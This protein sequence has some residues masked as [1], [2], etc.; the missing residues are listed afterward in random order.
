ME[1]VIDM[2]IP[3]ILT[4]L[5]YVLLVIEAF[6]CLITWMVLREWYQAYVYRQMRYDGCPLCGTS[7]ESK[8]AYARTRGI[9]DPE[10]RD[11]VLLWCPHCQRITA[12]T[13]LLSLQSQLTP[14]EYKRLVAY[15]PYVLY[16]PAELRTYGCEYLMSDP[17]KYYQLLERYRTFRGNLCR[18]FIETMYNYTV[19]ME[20]IHYQQKECK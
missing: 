13:P 6:L 8:I 12:I 1:I 19:H 14:T 3:S 18:M 15:L 11:V 16:D 4:Y 5:F 2:S 17:N 9:F 20:Q 7:L 10:D